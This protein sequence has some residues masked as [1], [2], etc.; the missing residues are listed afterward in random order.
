MRQVTCQLLL[1]TVALAPVASQTARPQLGAEA[2]AVG[3]HNEVLNGVRIYYRV[4]GGEGGSPQA[5]P[6]VFLHGGPGYNSYSF[7]VFEGVRIEPQLRMVYLDQRGC[8]R[9][10]R[11]W[12]KEYSIALLVNDIESLRQKL[13][14]PRLSLI[15]HSFGGA[16][17]LEY[18]ARYPQHVE[19]IVLVD[20]FSD[21]PAS[22]AVWYERVQSFNPEGFAA[23]KAKHSSG[24]GDRCAVA[25]DNLALVNEISGQTFFNSL[26]FVDQSYREK[27]DRLDAA[28]GLKNTGE[29]SNALFSNGLACYT[30]LQYEKV[31]APV[32]VI[33]GRFDGAIGLDPMRA[34]AANLPHATFLEYEHSAHFPY[35]EESDRFTRDVLKFLASAA[36]VQ[37]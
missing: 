19:K 14:V 18:A 26:Q 36:A 21:G 29:Q 9:S 17:A 28:S 34:M 8:G 5:A 4:A 24:T 10:E 2:A 25:K 11:P 13:G 20:G 15:G 22:I 37:P 30:F 33:G 7:S 27:Q 12:N 32:L 1:A 16:L 31:T 3:E 23:A 35:L 6:V